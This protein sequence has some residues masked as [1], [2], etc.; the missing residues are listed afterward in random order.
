[1]HILF[2]TENFPPELNAAATRVYERAVHWVRWGHQVTVITCAPNFPQGRVFPGYENKWRQEEMMDGIRVIRVKTFIAKNQGFALRIAD[3]LS[4][5]VTATWAGLFVKKPDVVI[6]TSPQFFAA[7]AGWMLGKFKRKPFVFELGDIWPAS[8]TAVGAMKESFLLNML[9]KFELFLYRQSACVAAL[10]VAFKK[11][12]VGRN[13]PPDKIAVVRNG[14]D[15]SRYAP[16]PK[17]P[18]LAQQ[19]DLEGKFVI[20]Y[21]G[22]LGM[23]H[24]LTNVLQAA[25]KL[26]DLPD[27]RF[28]LM[29]PGAEREKL[30][31]EA[32]E[33]G[34]DN[35]VFIPPQPKSTMPAHWSLCDCA[36]VHLKNIP[37]FE[38]VIPSKIF[39]AMGMG[40]P[41]L[42]ASPVGEASEIVV[43]E[44]AGLH[45]PGEDPQALAD[46]ARWLMTDKALWARLAKNSH[47][48]APRYSREKQAKEM[49]E[50]LQAAVDGRGDEIGRT[51][52]P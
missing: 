40:R 47:A 13:I 29:G 20:G 44:E 25:E 33:R 1:M 28:L 10:T 6:S 43:K 26:R 3:F 41:M 45:V 31:K 35:V 34:L 8:I 24:A 4:Y 46:A 27:F 11:D 7:V 21:I 50:V 22:T 52:H 5:M 49:I 23:A 51:V 14:V 19:W 32:E 9:E 42:F 2:L 12:L 15:L 16:R 38:T 18:E 37:L 36:L 17:D 39:E 30:M 48:A